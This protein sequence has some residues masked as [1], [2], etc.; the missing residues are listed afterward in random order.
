MA[1]GKMIVKKRSNALAGG[2][3]HCTFIT[4]NPIAIPTP[5]A[6][7][8]IR[9]RFVV[10]SRR[11]LVITST[12]DALV[13]NATANDFTYSSGS[14]IRYFLTPSQS[15]M[16]NALSPIGPIAFLSKP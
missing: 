10:R 3:A 11:S 15:I 13:I 14:G 12:K 9:F 5:T 7:V 2:H 16:I 6:G 4:I 1:A 8:E